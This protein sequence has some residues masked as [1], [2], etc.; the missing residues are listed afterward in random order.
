MKRLLHI[1]AYRIT[2]A[3]VYGFSL[4]PMKLLYA[5][6]SVA[7]FF[8]Y[9]LFGYRKAVVIQN[10]SRSFPEKRYGEIQAVAKKF[11]ICFA[12]YFAEI[13]K[14]L[15]APR[16]LLDQKITFENLELIRQY[17]LSGRNVIACLGHCGNWEMLNI[18]P[19]KMDMDVYAVYKPLSSKTMNRL[20][21]KI[22][23]RFG[24]KLISD[25]AV[26]RHI[27]SKRHSPAVYL[28]LADQCPPQAEEKYSFSFLNQETYFF[29][30][31]DKLARIGQASVI[32]LHIT[33]PS[34]GCYKVTCLPICPK[35]A[36]MKEGEITEK[37]VASLEENII[38]EPYGWL[39]THRRWKN[40]PKV[41]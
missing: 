34:R 4:L 8:A 29:S 5:I 28:F 27:L 16:E 17:I 41:K 21:I 3:L 1:L 32:Y 31:L 22:R 12:N 25:K 11:Y 36:V 30:S 26:I 7:F 15:S 38:E 23:S 18:L 9:Y 24:I 6:A 35:A 14:G 20:M 40:T 33:Q 2:Y 10:I 13:I 19:D 37:F 39:W